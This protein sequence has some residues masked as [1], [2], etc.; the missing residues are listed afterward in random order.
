MRGRTSFVI[1][2]RLA[3]VRNADLILVFEDGHIVERGSH[4]DLLA[5]Q[6]LYYKLYTT[7]FPG[8][9]VVES[10]PPVSGMP[11]RRMWG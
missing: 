9:D 6:G 10:G 3:T 8:K 4:A 5:M 2:H 11:T 7:G 1:A